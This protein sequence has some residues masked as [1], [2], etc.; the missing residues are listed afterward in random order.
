M[1][2][3]DFLLNRKHFFVT[4][5]AVKHIFSEI[6]HHE[7]E[8]CGLSWVCNDQYLVSGSADSIVNVYTKDNVVTADPVSFFIR[9]MDS[10]IV[11]IF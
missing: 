2:V 11:I 3:N 10:N 8:V 1:F 5:I 6:Q 4:V 7:A 9:L